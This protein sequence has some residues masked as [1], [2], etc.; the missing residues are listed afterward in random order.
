MRAK[1]RGNG[2]D[3]RLDHRSSRGEK[4][5][6]RGPTFEASP[7]GAPLQRQNVSDGG[8]F[9]RGKGNIDPSGCETDFVARAKRHGVGKGGACI[10]VASRQPA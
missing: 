9:G 8:A 6:R 1:K 7:F 3:G 10:T 2:F 5:S 4:D